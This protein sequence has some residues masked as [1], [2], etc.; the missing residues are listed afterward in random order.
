MQLIQ[1]FSIKVE[2][3]EQTDYVLLNYIRGVPLYILVVYILCGG[4]GSP[5]TVTVWCDHLE[6][7]PMPSGAE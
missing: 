7:T 1:M 5:S 4:L 6:K 2:I 3:E